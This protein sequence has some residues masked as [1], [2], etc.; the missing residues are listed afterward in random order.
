MAINN[1]DKCK[2][3]SAPAV[4]IR[5]LFNSYFQN[6]VKTDGAAAARGYQA[7]T[8]LSF[9]TVQEYN[10]GKV[11]VVDAE[12]SAN[13]PAA[14]VLRG[15]TNNDSRYVPDTIRPTGFNA[16]PSNLTSTLEMNNL[17]GYLIPHKVAD[18]VG[19]GAH[20]S[21][22]YNNQSV[23]NQQ[24]GGLTTASGYCSLVN[25]ESL[26]P[27]DDLPT[28]SEWYV[29]QI[30]W[31]YEDV[32][33]NTQVVDKALMFY[34]FFSA[35]STRFKVGKSISALGTSSV[36]FNYSVHA[37]Q[38]LYHF[39]FSPPY[40]SAATNRYSN[41]IATGAICNGDIYVKWGSPDV[42]HTHSIENAGAPYVL[43][44]NFP[45]TFSATQIFE[46]E[47]KVGI[48]A[49]KTLVSTG[50]PSRSNQQV[51]P[52]YKTVDEII[53]HFADYG[54]KLY[55]DLDECVQ[56]PPSEDGKIN[57]DNPAEQIPYFAD[58]STEKTP[59]EQA[60]ITPSTFAQSCVY[61][62]LSTRDF[63]RWICDNTVDIGNWK[64]LFANPVDVI[65]GINLYNLD[66][67]AHD[68]NHIALNS[69]TNILGVTSNIPNYS[70]LD[71]Y[72]NIISGGT[73]ELQAYYGNY[74]DF[75]SMTYQMFIPFV[76]F[77]SLRACDVVNHTLHLYYAV[78]FATGS[79]VAFVNSD[80]RLIYSSPCTVAGKIPLST[81]DK[82][83]QMINNTL[84][85]LGSVGG[86]MGG[87]ASG[88]VGGGVGAL[89]NGLGGLQMQ[90][91]YSNKGSLSAVNIYKL[92]PAF[93]ERTRYDLFFP[94]DDQQYLGA[95]YQGAAGAPSTYF[96][97][98]INSADAGGF[99][100]ADV[101]YLTSQTATDAEKQQIISLIKSGIYL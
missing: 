13:P 6:G 11:Y 22:I 23:N 96:D 72:N 55:T 8:C 64:R 63:L 61:N 70:I 97:A 54:V 59:I 20:I 65:T 83:S 27:V 101:V 14:V 4:Q 88:N 47:D 94:S 28:Y 73:L 40:V 32:N 58:N 43:L 10:A 38:T 9:Q 12:N 87:I 3:I 86:L 31:V 95:K 99:V 30:Q 69:A 16:L 74:A 36:Y 26:T 56:A 24:M 52:A 51:F 93:I 18:F 67:P 46:V 5:A 25:T 48:S 66:I 2:A 100:Q 81:S 60:Y 19:E 29:P 92:L 90:T 41:A 62:P 53:S 39:A 17:R 77:T 50:L 82:N 89:L 34:Y 33:G 44:G 1:L 45:A 84:S 42:Y 71:G 49:S 21:K 75:T 37:A 80:D 57:P 79:A 7:T 15:T 98:L 78:D 35:S 68:N 76:G 85:I 91:N